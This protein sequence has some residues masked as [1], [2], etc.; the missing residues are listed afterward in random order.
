M[1]AIIKEL[2]NSW[3]WVV[4]IKLQWVALYIQWVATLQLMQLVC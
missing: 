3:K 1:G 2:H 4:L